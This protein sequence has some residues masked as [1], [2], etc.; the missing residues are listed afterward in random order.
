MIDIKVITSSS[1]GTNMYLLTDAATGKQAIVDCPP[2]RTRQIAFLQ[3]NVTDKLEYILLT[4][5]HFDHILGLG[6]MLEQFG[7]KI[8]IHAADAD[9]LHDHEK[10]LCRWTPA[11][12]LHYHADITVADGDEI[13]LGESVL[14]VLHTPGHTEGAVCYLCD[15]VLFSGDTLFKETCGRVDFPGGDPQK[16]QKSL[17][18]LAGLEG[19]KRVLPGHNEETTLA[20]ERK[21]NPYIL[22]GVE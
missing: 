22:H 4:H 18:R 12:D 17:Q 20:Y 14:Q 11:K 15:D 3:E 5:G 1:L 2:I 7:G 6:D 13:T 8:V 16:M 9:C 10:A 21:H 19:D